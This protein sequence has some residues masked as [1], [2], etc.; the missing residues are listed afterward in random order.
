MRMSNGI[1][2][3]A[4]LT[5]PFIAEKFT[6]QSPKH[7]WTSV[8]VLASMI[9]FTGVT[10]YALFASG[11]LQDWAEPKQEED[12]VKPYAPKGFGTSGQDT[13]VLQ[14][15][16]PSQPQVP[17]PPAAPTAAASWGDARGTSS[18]PSLTTTT[19]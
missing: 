19:V 12:Q 17:P 10:F 6:A 9:H 7:G 5:C 3:L 16:Q 2:I 15:M 8:F 18:V 1:G 13:D 4:D 14:G 11:E